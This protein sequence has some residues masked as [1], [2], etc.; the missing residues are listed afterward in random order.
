MD[1]LG[2]APGPIGVFARATTKPG[3]RQEF[4]DIIKSWENVVRNEPG[5][6]FYGLFPDQADENLVHIYQLYRNREAISAHFRDPHYVKLLG[7]IVQLSAAP[8]Q[9]SLSN[10][11][12]FVLGKE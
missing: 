2:L 12:Y 7:A 9:Y 3:R 4:V 5:V 6:L 1:S 10:P 11:A 8:P